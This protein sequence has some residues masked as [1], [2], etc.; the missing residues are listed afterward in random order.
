M[1][2][3]DSRQQRPHV[4]GQ[5]SRTRSFTHRRL[6]LFSIFPI[7]LQFLPC[8]VVKDTLLMHV[9]G[10]VIVVVGEAEGV[11]SVVSSTS[12]RQKSHVLGHASFTLRPLF[13]LLQYCS[14]LSSS[15]FFIHTQ[16]LMTLS[17]VF[18][19]YSLSFLQHRPQLCGLRKEEYWL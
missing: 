16:A 6:R 14:L 18:K 9:D 11:S 7:Q 4:W 5:P 3:D 15:K 13:Q 12:S 10:V 19:R 17:S 1:N 2:V 8:P